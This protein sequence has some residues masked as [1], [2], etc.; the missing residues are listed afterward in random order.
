MV[1]EEHGKGEER[2]PARR[3]GNP[4]ASPLVDSY[5]TF[6]SEEQKQ[7]GVPVNQAAPMLEHTLMD[8]LSDMRSR[9]QVASSL[10]ERISLTRNIAPVCTGLFLDAHGIQPLLY[11]GV[12]NPEAPRI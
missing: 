11:S 3:V 7:V 12:A 10:A 9:A 2:D 1:M 5:L 6:V 8:L 4:C